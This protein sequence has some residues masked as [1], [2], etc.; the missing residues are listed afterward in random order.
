MAFVTYILLSA[1]YSG[2]AS[3]FHPQVLGMVA[4]R[5]FAIVLA[6]FVFINLGCYLL[7]ITGSGQVT[8]LVSY[9]GYKFVG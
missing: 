9:G 8:D 7:N 5:A 1:L 2:L 6:E 3:R 4:S